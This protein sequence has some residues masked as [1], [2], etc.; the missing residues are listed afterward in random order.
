M[1]PKWFDHW[2]TWAGL[3]RRDNSDANGAYTQNDSPEGSTGDEVVRDQWL[4]YKFGG[5]GTLKKSGALLSAEGAIFHLL[6]PL[7]AAYGP[8]TLASN[9]YRPRNGVPPRSLYFNHWS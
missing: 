3:N 6:V 9:F 1:A 2:T 5:P 4:K 7:T 8:G